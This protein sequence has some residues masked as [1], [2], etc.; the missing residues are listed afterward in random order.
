MNQHDSD[1]LSCLI[2]KSQMAWLQNT[3][4]KGFTNVSSVVR[5][6]IAEKM[7]QEDASEADG[8]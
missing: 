4:E 8:S 5:R 2:L 7:E 1:Q 6:L 3:A